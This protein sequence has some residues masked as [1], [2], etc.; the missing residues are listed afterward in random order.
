M[1]DVHHVLLQ[2]AVG[3]FTGRAREYDILVEH[4][5]HR[6]LD[7]VHLLHA[8]WRVLGEAERCGVW[9][10]ELCLLN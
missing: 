9:A 2:G 1:I 8:E 10:S 3:G 6:A 7:R 4:P 5:V